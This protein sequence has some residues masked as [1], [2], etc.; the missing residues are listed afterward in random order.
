M[1]MNN[2][3]ETTNALET[4][5][6]KIDFAAGVE[7]PSTIFTSISEL[8]NAL[9]VID[10]SLLEPFYTDIKSS[11]VLDKFE[12]GPIKAYL[13]A[14]LMALD[15]DV[16]KTLDWKVMVGNFL[17]K[18]KYSILKYLENK[19]QITSIDEVKELENEV[20]KHAKECDV[21]VIPVYSSISHQKL[22]NGLLNIHNAISRLNPKDDAVYISNAGEARINREFSISPETID[23]L[24]TEH[25]YT[26]EEEM[27]LLIKKPDY[28]GKSM[29]DVQYSG[30][31]IQV[32]ILDTEWLFKFQSQKT[33]VLPGDS[34]KALVRAEYR[35]GYDK[36]LIS[37]HYSVTKVMEV[38]KSI[39]WKQ[40][41]MFEE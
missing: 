37:E 26:A 25:I 10:R 38:L 9:Q 3:N 11:L 19:N 24:L 16:L 12:A 7:N 33:D 36:N 39:P 20:I 34:I 41:Q 2:K 4:F 5:A 32:K 6:L 18:A 27:T 17:V 15:E 14:N 35:Y 21:E 1:M 30:K 40:E 8:I 29:W 28:L 13:R 22:L 31:T 23:E